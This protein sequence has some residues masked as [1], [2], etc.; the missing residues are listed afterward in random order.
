M[1]LLEKIAAQRNPQSF[2]VGP[3]VVDPHDAAHGHDDS[4]FSP[5]E[6]GNYIATSNLIYSLCHLRARLLAAL[7]IRMYTNDTPEKQE[8]TSGPEWD[9]LRYVNPFWTPMRLKMQT[10][11]A[12]DLWGEAYWVIER[13]RRGVPSEIWWVKP[14]HMRPVPH[15]DRYLAGFIFTPSGGG[16]EVPFTAD[17][18]I[19]IRNPN[20]LDEFS[21]LSPLA[22]A[23]LA[24]DTQQA[25]MT[26]NK[27]IF[28][29]GYNIGGVITPPDGI[30]YDEEPAK[31][32]EQL[33][34][35]RFRGADRSHR[36]AVLRFAAKFETMGVTP[37]D[38]EWASGLN[39]TLR[40]ACNAYA[41][42]APLMNDLEHATLANVTG[43]ARLLWENG[44]VPEG[45][46]FAEE[47]REQLLPMFRGSKVGHFEHDYTK[48]AALQ[49]ALNSQWDRERGQLETGALT[50]NEWRR[51]RGLPAVPWGDKWWAQVNRAP[52]ATDT[53]TTIPAKD[54]SVAQAL[55]DIVLPYLEVPA[56]TAAFNLDANG[57]H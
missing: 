20:P 24:A 26:A 28:D 27:K 30:T 48:V 3:G 35:T 54:A 1:G 37:K 50:I 32:L 17:E 47:L 29:Q 45:S 52:I 49:D 15:P 16:P 55:A 25:M 7:P 14:T 6:Y 36:W 10:Q 5:E 44:L 4:R 12:K 18:V 51:R 11:L 56:L 23:R 57:T 42:P 43:F 41:V 22:A 9:L 40:E 53:D 2:L 33:L 19:W 13:D 34:E 8:I 31:R 21:A 46:F 38:A 39:I